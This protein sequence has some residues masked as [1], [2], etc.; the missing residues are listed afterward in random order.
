MSSNPMGLKVTKE[1]V[2][3]ALILDK[4]V[5]WRYVSD[6]VVTDQRGDHRWLLS[7][8]KLL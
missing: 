1:R 3:P 5:T 8:T 7:V 4:T 6:N 2:K